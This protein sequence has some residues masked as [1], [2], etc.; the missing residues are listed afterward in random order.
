MN[1]PRPGCCRG[2]APQSTGAASPRPPSGFQAPPGRT[3]GERP[4]PEGEL[5]ADGTAEAVPSPSCSPFQ[6]RRSN[7]SMHSRSG[8]CR[9][10]G[11]LK[12]SSP[13]TEASIAHQYD[14]ALGLDSRRRRW[15]PASVALRRP[16]VDRAASPAPARLDPERQDRRGYMK[17]SGSA[18]RKLDPERFKKLSRTPKTNSQR[19]GSTR[20]SARSQGRA[21][22]S[23]P[24]A[25][26]G[27]TKGP[28]SLAGARA[29]VWG[30]Q[31]QGP[32]RISI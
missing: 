16:E 7:D 15:T 1:C 4:R 3:S 30:E 18:S 32:A 31:K 5:K 13:R 22:R 27:L 11:W 14:I 2:R 17:N 23:R 8:G 28:G 10:V 21:S 20:C 24:D 19:V 26:V 6:S 25:K 29:F 9:R 12:S